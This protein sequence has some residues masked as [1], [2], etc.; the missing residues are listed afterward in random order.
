ML[1]SLAPPLWWTIP[2]NALAPLGENMSSFKEFLDQLGG[3]H[4]ARVTLLRWRPEAGKLR[5]EIDDLCSNFKGLPEYPGRV[6]GSVELQE[7]E[8]IRIEIDTSEK[9]LRIDSFDTEPIGLNKQR[10]SVTF[11][12]SGRIV[13]DHGGASFPAVK[14]R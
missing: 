2:G 6:T 9:R 10:S 1:P 12:P 5:F 14:L 11:W 8:T 7:V 13:A 4:D 3:L